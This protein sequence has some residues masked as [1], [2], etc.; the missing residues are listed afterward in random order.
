MVT[1]KLLRKHAGK[2]VFS[3][4]KIR[5][6]TAT[7]LV[8]CLETD[9]ITDIAPS[10]CT[11]FDLPANKST[12]ILPSLLGYFQTYIAY[13]ELKAFVHVC[14]FKYTLSIIYMVYIYIYIYNL[15][16]RIC[17]YVFKIEERVF[18]VTRESFYFLYYLIFF[19]ITTFFLLHIFLNSFNP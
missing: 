18:Y 16:T 1:Q 3:G 5:F 19:S 8:K 2:L 7:D 15:Y 12:M 9:Q 14:I 10:I 13:L 4:K 17:I 6:V 11:F